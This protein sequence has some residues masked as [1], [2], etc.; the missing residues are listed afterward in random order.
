GDKPLG[1]RVVDEAGNDG[2]FALKRDRNGELRD[3]V[4]EVGGAVE[5]IDNPAMGL[6]GSLLTAALLAQES[7][8]RPGLGEFGAKD[9]LGAVIGGGDEIG[10][11]PERG[12]GMLGLGENKA[13]AGAGL[14]GGGEQ[15]GGG[16]RAKH[17]AIAVTL[18]LVMPG[19]ASR[20]HGSIRRGSQRRGWPDESGRYRGKPVGALHWTGAGRHPAASRSRLGDVVEPGLGGLLGR[21][22]RSRTLLF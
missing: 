2:A 6:V 18:R 8:A 1:R 15:C 10:R 19:L 7:V 3:A 12:L 17:A 16:G 11:S 20:I 5:R 21:A 14:G 13:G 9:F 22:P 4:Q